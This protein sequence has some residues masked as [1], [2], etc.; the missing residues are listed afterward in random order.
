VRGPTKPKSD[1]A[2]A[3]AKGKQVVGEAVAKVKDAVAP[4]SANGVQE[5][6]HSAEPTDESA[7]APE[8]SDAPAQDERVATPSEQ[9]ESSNVNVLQTPN[10]EGETIR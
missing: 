3:V 4:S 6:E 5:A 8:T 10:F 9:A 1:A 7:A 2:G